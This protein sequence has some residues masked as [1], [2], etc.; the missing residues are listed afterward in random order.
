MPKTV[1]SARAMMA[2]AAAAIALGAGRASAVQAVPAGPGPGSATSSEATRDVSGLTPAARLVHPDS[3]A[4]TRREAAAELVAIADPP[5]LDA[6][7]AALLADRPAGVRTLAA[8]A[9]AESPGPPPAV[10]ARSLAQ[11]LE[12]TPE[13]ARAALLAALARFHTREAVAPVIAVLLEPAP[14]MMAM[15]AFPGVPARAIDQAQALGTLQRQTG[16]TDLPADPQGL[17]AWWES[18]RAMDE[19]AWTESVLA[20]SAERAGEA[21]ARA[22][23]LARRTVELY[24]RL[25]AATPEEARSDLLAELIRDERP[26]LKALGLDLA[27]RAL[28]NAR[29]LSPAVAQAAAAHLSDGQPGLRARVASLLE[30]MDAGAQA[31]DARAALATTDDPAVA[32]PLLRLLARHPVRASRAAVLRW[33][34]SSGEAFAAAVDAALALDRA[35]WF[36]DRAERDLVRSRLAEL[37]AELLTPAALSLRVSLGDT[38]A[39]RA[40]L[41]AP[42]PSLAA[43]AADALADDPGSVDTLI[44]AARAVA[45]NGGAAAGAGNGAG[46]SGGGAS[47]GVGSAGLTAA[48]IR[49]LARH[50]LT[51]QGFAAAAALPGPVTDARRDQML[52][53]AERLPVDQLL[54]VASAEAD[55]AA[56]DA[57]LT[58]ALTPERLSGLTDSRNDPLRDLVVLAARTRLALRNP[59][60]ALAVLDGVPAAVS[61][62]VFG[63]LKVT[64]LVWLNRLDD[65]A[66]VGDQ[67]KTPASA[68][69]DGLESAVELPH[70]GSAAARIAEKF[71]AGLTD[72]ERERLDALT[73]RAGGVAAPS[74]SPA[75]PVDRQAG[76][77][78]ARPKPGPTGPSARR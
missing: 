74:A 6:I 39:V 60:G 35:G 13:G 37:P 46:G 24:R 47:G 4:Q 75:A 27:E 22:E 19:A 31:Q 53:Y 10:L 63:P 33:L 78:G 17:K 5:A 58:P 38:A 77:P 16:R 68:W 45:V 70:A 28:L 32:A 34:G 52:R 51:A 11:A 73:K 8:R 2:A 25:H 40:M 66:A 71:G 61:P 49:A 29:T 55:P 44:E 41:R 36:D 72:G 57:L 21:A 43:A 59:T 3:T 62:G 64:A 26:E 9:I 54:L 65:A 76:P 23:A 20:Y 1:G 15:P 18:A 67:A 30:R 48:A 12:R 56:R 50:R 69:L 14:A 7:R 42:T